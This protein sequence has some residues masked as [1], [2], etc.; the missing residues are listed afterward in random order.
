[1]FG[2]HPSKDIVGTTSTILKGKKVCM[3]ITGSVAAMTAPI[4]A[5]E[6]M[7]LGAEVIAV[8][9]KSATQ[10]ITADLMHWA[11]GNPAITTLTGGVEHVQIAGERTKD[12]PT[13]DIIL[14]CPATANTISKI[15]AGID[16][17]PV[18]TVVTTA[19]GSGIPIVIVPAMHETM[20][21]HPILEE[22]ILKLKRLG[23]EFIGPRISEGKAKIARIDEIVNRCRD[24][25]TGDQGLANLKFLLTV[26]PTREYFDRVR[27]ISNP[28][29]GKM[30]MAIA[31]EIIARGGQVTII[32]TKGV[33]EPPLSNNVRSI[34]VTSTQELSDAVMKELSE[35]TY[36]FFISAAAVSDFRPEEF[37]D[38]K[39]SS[40]TD[41]LIIKLVP[42]PKIIKEVREAYPD[43]FIVAFKAEIPKDPE[44]MIE[45]AYSTLVASDVDLIVANDVGRT[46]T[47]FESPTNEVYIIDKNKN[48]CHEPLQT[49]RLIAVKLID[50]ILENF[51]EK[52]YERKESS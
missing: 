30:G 13:A 9:S 29:S 1:M 23:V 22:N 43:L 33:P 34:D 42:T 51:R 31:E 41:E 21:R 37:F 36:Q 17:T 45:K 3:C 15:A 5:R 24:I 20:Y 16:D 19:F 50:K 39:I 48:V 27:F 12:V 11:T 14:V 38:E 40:Q 49:K 4:I 2:P 35:N 26:G 47:G 32:M 18:T 7:R 44:E 25:M 52:E 46:D 28:S 8:M 6:F 10:L